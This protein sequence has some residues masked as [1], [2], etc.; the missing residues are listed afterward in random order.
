MTSLSFSISNIFEKV[1]RP[2]FALVEI[3]KI[4]KHETCFW[5]YKHKHDFDL[6]LFQNT[7]DEV[8]FLLFEEPL[9]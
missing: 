8:F 9:S 4:K 5:F 2:V 6:Q 7:F 1:R 3:I